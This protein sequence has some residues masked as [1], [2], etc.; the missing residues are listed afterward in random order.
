[1]NWYQGEVECEIMFISEYLTLRVML[2]E[3]LG[4]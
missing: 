2:I 4:G 3:Q 1:M